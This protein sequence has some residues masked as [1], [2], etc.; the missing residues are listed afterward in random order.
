MSPAQTS[1]SIKQGV[2]YEGGI[3]AL[4]PHDIISRACE[5]AAGIGF[6]LVV[7]RGTDPDVEAVIGGTVPIGITVRS[8]EREGA[9]NSGDVKYSVTETMAVMRKGGIWC[10]NP[11]GCVPGNLVNYVEATGVL[12]TGAPSGAAETALNG[13]RWDSTA[14]AGELALLRL[15]GILDITAGT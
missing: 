9:A 10:K 7:S 15:D 12:G 8:L 3:Y 1:Y 4:A 6:G 14:A 2:A 11:D 13:A 5:T